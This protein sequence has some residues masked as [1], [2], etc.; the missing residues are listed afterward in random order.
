MQGSYC[1]FC[2]PIIIVDQGEYNGLD[3]GSMEEIFISENKYTPDQWNSFLQQ[4]PYMCSYVD[5]FSYFY[6][7]SY[8]V[9]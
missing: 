3:R 7:F 9:R 6:V 8:I 5:F 4:L 1:N 2:I